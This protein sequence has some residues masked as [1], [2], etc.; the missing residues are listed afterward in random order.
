MKKY[1]QPSIQPIT[2]SQEVMT[3][4][5]SD[6]EGNEDEFSNYGSFDDNTLMKSPKNRL[7]DDTDDKKFGL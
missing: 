2:Y 5:A 4:G 7:W 1:I 3:L 6:S